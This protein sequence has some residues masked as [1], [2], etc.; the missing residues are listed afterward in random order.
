MQSWVSIPVLSV[1]H[2]YGCGW[3]KNPQLRSLEK[4]TYSRELTQ[5]RNMLLQE[6]GSSVSLKKENQ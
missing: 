3:E 2:A 4:L 1:L 5:G 6:F